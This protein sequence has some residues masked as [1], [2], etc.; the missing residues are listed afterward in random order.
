MEL[1]RAEA[2]VHAVVVVVVLR[3]KDKISR[4]LGCT[5]ENNELV[6]GV[7]GQTTV[8]KACKPRTCALIGY[9]HI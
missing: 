3:H 2:T 5:S 4:V 7:L 1:S 8:G 6:L 9:K